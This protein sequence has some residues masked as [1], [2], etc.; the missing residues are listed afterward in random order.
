MNADLVPINSLSGYKVMNQV[1][2]TV[3]STGNL[4][5]S[6]SHIYHIFKL[7]D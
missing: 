2:S 4:L 5:L 1:K 3:A 6:N 7:F